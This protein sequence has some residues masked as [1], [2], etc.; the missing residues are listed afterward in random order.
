M[1]DRS[2]SISK[3]IFKHNLEINPQVP[4]LR[5]K[6]VLQTLKPLAATI[7]LFCSQTLN[8]R[9][10]IEHKLMLNY[11]ESIIK[12]ISNVLFSL[13][14]CEREKDSNN[15]DLIMYSS[16]SKTNKKLLEPISSQTRHSVRLRPNI[17][18]SFG[19]VWFKVNVSSRLWKRTSFQYT[20][21]E[22]PSATCASAMQTS[23]GTKCER[24]EGRKTRDS[25]KII[26][27]IHER[28]K[29][30]KFLVFSHQKREYR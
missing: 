29:Q 13:S 11:V 10:R 7:N 18:S 8:K 9:R 6:M 30:A 21:A 20:S 4:W 23:C 2:K 24:S 1:K 15:G 28:N 27:H 19:F 16:M 26:C 22:K 12:R 14:N 5:S 17:V 25:I 3:L